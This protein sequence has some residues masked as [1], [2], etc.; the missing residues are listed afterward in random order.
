[1]VQPLWKTIWQFLK[2]A[3]T[4]NLQLPYIAAFAFLGIYPREIKFILTPKPE[5]KLL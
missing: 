3:K 4:K 2:K 1:M 5:H